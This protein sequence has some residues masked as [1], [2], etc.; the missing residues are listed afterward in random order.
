MTPRHHRRAH[1]TGRRWDFLLMPVLLVLACLVLACLLGLWWVPDV[2]AQPGSL[3]E[4]TFAEL[5]RQKPHRADRE[6]L[7]GRRLRLWH[8]A[9][10]I[11]RS[12]RGSAELAAGLLT[13]GLHESRFAELVG[14]GLCEEMPDGEQCDGGKARHYFQAHEGSCAALWTVEASTPE[15]LQ[16]ATDCAADRLRWA[17]S[18]CPTKGWLGAF[19]AYNVGSCFE[20]WAA[21]R[22][23]TFRALH[24]RL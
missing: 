14:A 7:D 20:S 22:E 24:A 15:A 10:A 6:S 2:Q 23:R 21:E 16:I 18:R 9:G 4:R 12:S 13:V 8:V 19:S 17:A 1:S 5:V 3:H 11:A